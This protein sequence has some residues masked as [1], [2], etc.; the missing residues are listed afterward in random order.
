MNRLYCLGAASVV[1]KPAGWPGR[2]NPA[3]AHQIR[4]FQVRRKALLRGARIKSSS[5]P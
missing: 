4:D 3:N 2:R 1:L 5:T